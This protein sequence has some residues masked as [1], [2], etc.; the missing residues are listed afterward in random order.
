[1]NGTVK[2]NII[3]TLSY[4]E[5]FCTWSITKLDVNTIIPRPPLRPPHPHPSPR[6]PR[7]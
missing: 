1:M 3:H 5:N 6:P 4:I 2:K 7:L